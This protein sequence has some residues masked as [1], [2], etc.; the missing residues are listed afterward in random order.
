MDMG[1]MYDTQLPDPGY[2]IHHFPSVV[3]ERLPG[4]L[5]CGF[6]P[7]G[8]RVVRTITTTMDDGG[9]RSIWRE[10]GTGTRRAL[11]LRSI[12]R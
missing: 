6:V 9:W 5:V 3:R 10:K 1:V 11:M 12:P 8:G 2:K 7:T 4:R